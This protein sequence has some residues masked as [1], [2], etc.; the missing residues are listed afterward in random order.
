MTYSIDVYNEPGKKTWTH[1]LH[2]W[3]FSDDK[4]NES[5]MH[6]YYRYQLHNS[7]IVRAHTKNRWEVSWSGKKIYSQKWHWTGRAWEKRS[8]LRK[9]WGIVF[10]PRKERNFT[11]KMPKKA[12]RKAMCG[13]LTAKVKDNEIVGLESLLFANIKT[14][15]A[16][17]MFNNIWL[18]W[19][20]LLVLDKK[21]ENIIKSVRNIAHVK[22]TYASHINPTDLLTHR[23]IICTIDALSA[24]TDHL[25][26]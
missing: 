8:P 17:V 3:I 18:N 4:I 16:A 10:W 6:E 9:K 2:E 23:N 7:R 20:I 14:K 25:S 15:D 19:T 5:L 11:L 13:L 24:I 1:E 22:Y 21:D 26:S 12:R